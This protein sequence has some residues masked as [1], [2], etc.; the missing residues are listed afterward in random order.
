[1]LN[2]K[3]KILFML[4]LV[5][6]SFLLTSCV[7][8]KPL[9]VRLEKE[10]VRPVS[11]EKATMEFALDVKNPNAIG[12]DEALVEYGV[13][14]G[15]VEVFYMKNV[16]I[17]IPGNSNKTNILP[18]DIY[19]DKI[20]K[21]VTKMNEFIATG[22]KTVPYKVKGSIGLNVVGFPVLVPFESEGQIPLP[23]LEQERINFENQ[24]N[25]MKDSFKISF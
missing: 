11:L 3:W 22:N 13:N 19:Y 16:K 18:V 23:D 20:F 6:C 9:E 5:S 14:V 25:K 7:E 8:I 17:S 1:M 15:D 21:T 4:S 10:R 12:V 24:L 2:H